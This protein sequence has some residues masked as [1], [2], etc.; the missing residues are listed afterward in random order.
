L[1]LQHRATVSTFDKP[2]IASR[3][4]GLI[5]G[6]AGGDLGVIA[7]QLGISEVALRISV[8]DLSPH[9][10]IDVIAA[11]ISHFA[12]DPTWLLTGDYD[13]QTHR[14]SL[15]GDESLVREA[16]AGVIQ[17]ASARAAGLRLI[18]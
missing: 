7:T 12:V 3:I 13:A 8:D 1:C 4:R 9:P 15:N 5:G 6:Q 16:V 11:V 10:T 17:P 14:R 18:G 2:G